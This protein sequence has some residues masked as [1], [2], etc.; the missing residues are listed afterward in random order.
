MVSPQFK[1][2]TQFFNASRELM[3]VVI[4]MQHLRN[5]FFSKS[6]YF[7]ALNQGIEETGCLIIV[8][9][10]IFSAGL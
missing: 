1:L 7:A 8:D 6:R 3:M 5:L 4:S 9:E 2:H 10:K